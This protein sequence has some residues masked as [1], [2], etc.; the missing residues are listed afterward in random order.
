MN[1]RIEAGPCSLAVKAEISSPAI[2]TNI[3]RFIKN[4]LGTLFW[5]CLFSAPS[6]N[7]HSLNA[8]NPDVVG[9][10]LTTSALA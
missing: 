4:S 7:G 9:G 1:V 3:N 8:V 10:E 2:N 6:I 5:A